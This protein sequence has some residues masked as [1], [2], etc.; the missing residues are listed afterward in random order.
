MRRGRKGD[1]N[2]PSWAIDAQVL[3][4]MS[5]EQLRI[6]ASSWRVMIV[7]IFATTGLN[8]KA[9]LIASRTHPPSLSRHT[10]TTTTHPPPAHH[11]AFNHNHIPCRTTS[12]ASHESVVVRSFF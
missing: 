3:G 9:R 1:L 11:Q 2:S 7:P 10:T 8:T 6:E 12:T 5:D 4:Y